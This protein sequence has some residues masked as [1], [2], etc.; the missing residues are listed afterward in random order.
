MYGVDSDRIALDIDNQK[1]IGNTGYIATSGEILFWLL[2]LLKPRPN[3]YNIVGNMHSPCCWR[4]RFTFM[5]DKMDSSFG[6]RPYRV[7]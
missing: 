5:F 4:C 2:E 1:D 3:Q 6:F 7:Y